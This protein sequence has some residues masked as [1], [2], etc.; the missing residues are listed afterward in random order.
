MEGVAVGDDDTGKEAVS[1]RADFC[2]TLLSF[3]AV[4]HV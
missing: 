3:H 1:F 4:V 2:F